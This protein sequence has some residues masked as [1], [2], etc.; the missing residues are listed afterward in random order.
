M[1]FRN[2]AKLGLVLSLAGTAVM[3]PGLRAAVAAEQP[4]AA[5]TEIIG[6]FYEGLTASMRDGP[7]LGG[8]GRYRK[9]EPLVDTTFNLPLMTQVAVGPRWDGLAPDQQ[10]KLIEAFRRF[11]IASYANHFD[12]YDGE[13]FDVQPEPQAMAGGTLVLTRLVPK[14]KQPIVLN[15]VMRQT[16][17]VWRV[18][19]VYAEGTIS[20]LARRRSEFS[21]V[22]SRN[23]V[24]ALTD[25]LVEKAQTLLDEP[26]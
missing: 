3:S 7:S 12:S 1:M 10:S 11:T 5:P 15:Y 24:D 26:A 19:D 22:L 16:G 6:K 23:G 25:R 4:Q 18:I 20:E 14:D 8:E 2:L 21:A 13:R 17:G 9:L